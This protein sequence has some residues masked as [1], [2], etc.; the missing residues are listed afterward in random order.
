MHRSYTIQY[1][2]KQVA[3]G[4]SLLNELLHLVLEDASFSS[5]KWRI[6]LN[7]FMNELVRPIPHLMLKNDM[8]V[9]ET[10][11]LQGAEII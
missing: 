4:K 10:M 3:V 1:L 11:N 6:R 7:Y 8:V 2:Y 5:L 9:T